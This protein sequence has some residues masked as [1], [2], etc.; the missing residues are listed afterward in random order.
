[1]DPASAQ[2]LFTQYCIG[3]HNDKLKTAGVSL[4]A[5]QT[6]DV[7]SGAATWERVLRKVRTGE[8]PPLNLPA[9][10]AST[11]AA[12]VDWLEA[13]L[14]RAAVAKPNPGAP[15]IHRLNRVEYS[16]AIRDL[17]GL[18]F[19]HAAGLP[20][21]DS[22]YGFDN[23]GDVLTVSPLHMEKYM[24]AARR[25]SRTA[26]GTTKAS[27][28]IEKFPAGRGSDW[29]DELPPN[30]R[31][32]ILVRRY[33]PLDAEYSILVRVRGNPAP[34]SPSSKLDLRVDGKR[35]QLFD[36]NI[37]TAEEAQD[38]RNYEMRL[39][40][41]AGMRAVAAGFLTD[42]QKTEGGQTGGRRGGAPPPQATPAS[43]ESVTIA[44]PFKPTG[45]GDT[46]SRKRI[47]VCRPA[48]GTPEG[49]CAN[50]IL[51]A[52]AR[53]AYRRPVATAD[54]TPLMK[55]FAMG[56]QD[57]GTFDAGIET[58]LRG[59]L[60]S[61]AFL[62]RVER[63]PAPA[64]PGAVHRTSDLE[65]ASRL[66]F[67]LWSSIPDEELQRLGEQKKLHEPAVLNAQVV[68]MLADPKAKAL[69]D[70]FAGQW[71]ELRNIASWRPDPEK[72]PNFDDPLREALRRE[73]ES[74]FQYIVKEDRSVLDFLDADYTF[75]N[76]RLARHYGLNG[77]RGNYFR[78]VALTTPERGGILTQGGILA[79]TSQPTRTSPVLRGKWILENVLGAPPP[80]P[81]PDVPVLADSA[82][83][84]AKSLREQLEKHR[85]NAA[86]ASC[87]VRLDPLGFA[88]EN[89]DPT[90]RFR[91][92]EGGAEIDASGSLPGGIAVVGPAGLKKV[93]LDR[94]DQ[95]IEC[96]AE[97]LLTY[98][99]GRGLEYYD[100]PSV[101]QVRRD[102]AAKDYR[103]SAMILS[104][105]NSVPFQMRRTPER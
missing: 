5:V 85:A 57:G 96:L 18:D 26:L 77:V 86:C 23:I 13:Q 38:T 102:T 67:F 39:P 19:D 34:N 17:L 33:F 79:V 90:G 48:A 16:N 30:E 70:N 51:T 42:Y 76:E 88:L 37:N 100:W 40:L 65:L 78:K 61:P 94:R 81:P 20:P 93:M 69:V 21:D 24:S 72:Y 43:V 64:V 9:P 58:A 45:P 101:R 15:A 80:P 2:K 75:V 32:G 7:A 41:Q 44:G 74:L 59:V 4:S 55:L 92:S 83:N 91:A 22:G 84:S 66:S 54:L 8:M 71:L 29:M 73:T 46:E 47:F 62:F 89:Y 14:D 49:P 104:I 87:H 6:A 50:R 36:V 105:V 35:V 95:F 103:F 31:G 28:A 11:R 68:R 97:K 82:S 63:D 12:L 60:V 52:L 1:M 25:I 98:G 99:L 3:C 27:A 53:R 10:D 56:R